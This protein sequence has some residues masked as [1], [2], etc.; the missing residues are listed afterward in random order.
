MRRE[1]IDYYIGF[2]QKYSDE[3]N[4]FFKVSKNGV[5]VEEKSREEYIKSQARENTQALIKKD[6]LLD[7]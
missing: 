5:R 7:E 2:L 4:I 1:L 3:N 6:L